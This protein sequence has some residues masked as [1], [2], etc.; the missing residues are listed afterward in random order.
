MKTTRIWH[1]SY[2]TSALVALAWMLA[3]TL[4]AATITWSGAGGDEL[5]SNP[6]NW[7]GGAVP[8]PE[9]DV[10]I[11]MPGDVTVRMDAPN[12]IVR[13]LQ[14]QESFVIEGG[15][16]TVTSGASVVNGAFRMDGGWYGNQTLA[17]AGPG[18]TFTVNGVVT[19]LVRLQV[20]G[21]AII[22]LPT[23]RQVTAS[24]AYPFPVWSAVGDGSAILCTNLTNLVVEADVLR[25]DAQNGAQIDLQALRSTEG[26]VRC[27]ATGSNSLVNLSGLSGLWSGSGRSGYP[28]EIF[29][30]EQG[31]VLIPNVTALNN[32][33]LSVSGAA[34]VPTAQLRSF[35]GGTLSLTS[36][37]NGF[38]GLTNFSGLLGANDSRLDLT[39]LTVLGTTDY[40]AVV[41]ASQ[42]SV[43]D[44]S[45]VTNALLPGYW[46]HRH[47]KAESGSRIDLRRL[48][49]PDYPIYVEVT[50]AGS[51]IDLTGMEGLWENGSLTASGGSVWI[52]NITAMHGVNLEIH[53][54]AVVPTEQLRSFTEGSIS[55]YGRTNGFD[56][57]TTFSGSVYATDSRLDLTNITTIHTTNGYQINIQAHQGG[58][59]DLS[60]LTNVMAVPGYGLQALAYSGG[61]ID[62]RRLRLG[63]TPLLVGA[64]GEGSWINLSGLNGVWR[65][66]S[67]SASSDTT[68]LMPNVTG[69][70]GVT[71]DVRG[72]AS[73]HLAQLTSIT[74]G[75]VVLVSRTNDFPALMEFT[76]ALFANDSRLD[77]T[78][79]TTLYATNSHLRFDADQGS[80]IDL[81]N[82]TNAVIHPGYSLVLYGNAGTIDL[83][84]AHIPEGS[85][86]VEARWAAGVVDLSGLSGLFTPGPNHSGSSITASQG[87]SVLISN[88][89]VMHRVHLSIS[90]EAVVPTAQLTSLT[91]GGLTVYNRTNVFSAL[92]NLSGTV[93]TYSVHAFNSHLSF[94]SLTQLHGSNYNLFRADTG[95]LIDLS[96][97]TNSL[98]GAY[99]LYLY[100]FG[101]RIDLPGVESIAGSHIDVRADG[102]GSVVDLR[103]LTALYSD[104]NSGLLIASGGGTILLNNDAML[105]AGV[106]IDFQDDP[107]GVLPPFLAPSQSLVLYGQPWQSYRIESRDPS[108][109]GSPWRLYRRV[110]LTSPLEIIGSR[111]PQ[112]LALRVHAFVADPPEVDVRLTAPDTIEPVIFGVPGRTYRL[113]TTTS[114]REPIGWE[115]GPTWTMTNSFFIVPSAATTNDARFH[116]A[117]QL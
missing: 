60:R 33:S 79:F 47:V 108:L 29:A 54:D 72:S 96:K 110:P 21:G 67:L 8:T 116:R 42:G 18:T 94:P 44:L 102:P 28:D 97:V 36:R 68:V 30:S 86:A 7:T 20:S 32:V 62:L 37:T 43:I 107:G 106:A 83:H 63:D 115:N 59:I 6:A 84:K 104:N 24:F 10:V 89:T 31:T 17:V 55:L 78:N 95:S 101:G 103:G 76:G 99:Y 23:A 65:G 113:E 64:D 12:T 91:E 48:R 13:S 112:D 41:G 77:L 109:A 81:S 80:V 92:T 26:W 85:V 56:G 51:V 82:V 3:T 114:L 70:E 16:F 87:G 11:N 100:A 25:I 117:R 46:P 93:N 14:C 66:G 1:V 40:Y 9:D 61:Q 15:P 38:E 34:V 49:N 74:A 75:S 90:D 45:R 19:N 53:N 35:T 71:L 69:L 111:P 98:V 5:W 88:V 2:A 52:S 73:V 50:D 105:L 39:N 58:F 22:A 27:F 57:L 4:P